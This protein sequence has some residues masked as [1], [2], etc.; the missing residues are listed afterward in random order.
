MTVPASLPVPPLDLMTRVG[1]VPGRD[2]LDWYLREGARLRELIEELLPSDWEWEGKRAL[3]F[4]CGAARVLRHFAP[5]AG[6]AEFYG[7]DIDRPTIAWNTAS[8]SPPFQFFSNELA[9]PVPL[10]DGSLDLIWAMSVFTHMAESWSAW[11]LELHRLLVPGGILI[12]S[13]LG[14]GMW[15]HFVGETYCEEEVGMVV[16]RHWEGPSASVFHSE[17]WLRE[18][19]GRAFDVLELR[20]P[21]RSADGSPEIGHSYVVLRRPDRSVTRAE[22]DRVSPGDQR[23]IAGLQTALRLARAEQMLLAFPERALPAGVTRTPLARARGG[24]RRVRQGL[25]RNS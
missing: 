1:T 4:G 7:C 3:D 19:W 20:Q 14:Q 13:F 9:P 12:A 15:P 2:P 18:H 16:F 10:S 6:V 8:L 11:L 5:R 21:P 23:E 24:L 17:W 22:L 25:L